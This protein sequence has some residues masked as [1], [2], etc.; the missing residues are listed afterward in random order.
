M[1]GNSI[2]FTVDVE[3]WYQVENLSS[4]ISRQSWDS[5]QARVETCTHRILNLLD[6]HN[7]KGTFFVLGYIAKRERSLVSEI[8]R[9]GHEVA[10]HGFEHRLI[11]NQTPE[12]FK[13][14]VIRS[15][16]LLEDITGAEVAGYRAPAFSITD[17]AVDI[18]KQV[19]FK[20]DSSLFPVSFHGRY[21][22]L[23]RLPMKNNADKLYRYSN[24]LL[25]VPCSVL[26]LLQQNIPWAGGG[27]FRITPYSIY[28]KGVDQILIRSNDFMF[29]IHPWEIDSNQPNVK[30]LSLTHRIRHYVNL[31]GT[32]GKLCKLCED[33]VL[34]SIQ[35]R[36][37]HTCQ[38]ALT[39]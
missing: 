39:E 18:L 19:G 9:R 20:Y 2:I 10:S 27:Y 8:S 15:K 38:V 29:Y 16:E 11:Y 21:G 14:D 1:K 36:L 25:E 7:A 30:G 28:K 22:R 34:I 17:W 37:N 5:Q 23:K 31:K 32:F 3:D 13:C 26:R 4:V 24:G 33:Y 12:Q 6:E 35:D